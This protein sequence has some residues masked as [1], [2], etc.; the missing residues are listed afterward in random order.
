MQLVANAEGYTGHQ[1]QGLGAERE[2]DPFQEPQSTDTG[3]LCQQ[4]HHF[5]GLGPLS[6]LCF[7]SQLVLTVSTGLGTTSD[8]LLA[9][10]TFLP[11]ISQEALSEY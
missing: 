9:T 4:H 3:S 5:P 1:L 10:Y 6:I 11:Q 2:A 7:L 8:Y